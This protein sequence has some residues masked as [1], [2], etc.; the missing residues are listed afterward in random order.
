MA[1][2]RSVKRRFS[3]GC[4]GDEPAGGAINSAPAVSWFGNASTGCGEI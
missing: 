2:R 1:K 3:T 4:E